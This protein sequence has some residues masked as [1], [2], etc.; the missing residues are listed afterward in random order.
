MVWRVQV[1][2]AGFSRW[3]N[4]FEIKNVIIQSTMFTKPPQSYLMARMVLF[5]LLD[6]HSS[7]KQYISYSHTIGY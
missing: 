1:L 5:K 2:E 6:N 3:A 7:D 4:G